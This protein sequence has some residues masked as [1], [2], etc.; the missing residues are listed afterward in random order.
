M[1]MMRELHLED[2]L[3]ADTHVKSM[4]HIILVEKDRTAYGLQIFYI[5][6][7]KN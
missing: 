2:L 1:S 6:S 3:G 7:E 4:V 5:K